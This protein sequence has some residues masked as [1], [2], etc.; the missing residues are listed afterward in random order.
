M[1]FYFLFEELGFPTNKYIAIYLIESF[2]Y[3]I[4]ALLFCS[5]LKKRKFQFLFSIIF[6]ISIILWSFLIGYLRSMFSTSNVFK[7]LCTLSFYVLI[8]INISLLYKEKNI[9]NVLLCCVTIFAVKEI[10]DAGYAILILLLGI[11]PR[12]SVIVV[13]E[14]YILSGLVNDII[15]ST[16]IFIPFILTNKRSDIIQ[17]KN[18]AIK[19]IVI[20]FILILSLVFI[21]TLV[22]INSESDLILY[23]CCEGLMALTCVL[24]LILRYDIIKENENKIESQI[25]AQVLKNNKKQYESLKSNI[26]IINMKTHDIKHQLAKYQDK[27]TSNEIDSLRKSI[28][29]YDRKI[30]TGNEVLD[31]V[32]FTESLKCQKYNIR[33]TSICDGEKLNQFSTSQI[34]YLFSNIIDNA[35]EATKDLSKDKRFISLNVKIK[36]SQILI[37]QSNYFNSDIKIENNLI[38]TTKKDNKNHGYGLKSIRH[39]VNEN[40]GTFNIYTDNDMFFLKIIFP[41]LEKNPNS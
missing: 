15:K 21:K 24:V 16:F 5:R 38:N 9:I 19:L 35:I 8:P 17:D 3:L 1:L 4:S 34:Y 41:L 12:Q 6:V 26:E 36:K 40:S 28:E 10:A 32:L 23:G 25:L 2:S 18:I 39:L 29:I 7:L 30:K 14:N 31:T 37:E 20:A 27:L 11:N 13:F 33:L 22:I